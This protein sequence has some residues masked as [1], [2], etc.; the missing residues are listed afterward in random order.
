MTAQKPQQTNPTKRPE[1]VA[2]VQRLTPYK[3]GKA[4]VEG[5]EN[6]LKL[7]SNESMRGP[8][9]KALEAYRDAAPS[10]Q[11]YPE[12][13][14]A[15]LRGAIADTFNLN[16]DLIVCGNGS[17][18]LI[19]LLMRAYLS[20]GDEVVLSEF[21]F[22]MAYVHAT[23]QGCGVL[24]ADEPGLK[25]DVDELLKHV[26]SKTRMVVLATPNNPVGQYMTAAEL[27]R[28]HA[29]LPE[30]VILLVDGAY[31]DY[32]TEND[33]SAG[34]ELVSNA[35]NC[36]MTRTF[37]KLYGLAALRIGWM[38]AP[39]H[40]VQSI[41]RIRTPFNA[42]NAA[43][44][45]ATEAV[46]DSEHAKFVR[47]ENNQERERIAAAL[48]ALGFDVIPSWANF[49]L[50]R[51][52]DQKTVEAAGAHLEANGIIPRPV[53]AGGPAACLRVTVGLPEQN[54]CVID[55]FRTFKA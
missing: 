1:P 20:P 21:S 41:Q 23:A 36:V 28:L 43:M 22:G 34:I 6:P 49:Y 26:T 4:V 39:E 8:S 16:P 5:V 12:G 11:F 27:H 37:S 3:Q 2:G 32:V 30:D 19:S 40:V 14:Q 17:D 29:A 50:I 10:L 51:F 9:P 31:A 35:P 47:D 18:E 25:P 55:A 24:W 13:S 42:N 38:Y 15:Q 48:K 52:D 33:Y 54:D 7:S 46:R 45:A 53:N 44:A